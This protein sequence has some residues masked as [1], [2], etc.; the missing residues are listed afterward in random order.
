MNLK[1]VGSGYLGA[2]S[3]TPILNAG[4][5]L[6]QNRI[7]YFLRKSKYILYD[8]YLNINMEDFVV[9]LLHEL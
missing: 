8:F 4:K 9:I 1:I 7:R 5:I 6:T 2:Y 3:L